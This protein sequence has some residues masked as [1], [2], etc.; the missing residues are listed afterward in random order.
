MT[1]H[2]SIAVDRTGPCRRSA[3]AV[4]LF[5]LGFSIAASAAASPPNPLSLN[6]S[7]ALDR[8]SNVWRV[9]EGWTRFAD[10]VLSLQIS[11]SRPVPISTHTRVVLHGFAGEDRYKTYDGLTHT[12][13]G[14]QAEFQYRS[15]GTYTA[16]IWGLALRASGEQ[17]KSDLRDSYRRSVAFTV[18][19]PITDRI[20]SF[21]AL[22]FLRR[23]GRSAVFDNRET[24]LRGDL[25]YSASRRATIYLGLDLRRGDAVS[26]APPWL[27][28]VDAAKAIALDD[29]FPSGTWYA[30]KVKADT[31]LGTLGF[32]YAL[33]TRHA[34]DVS[35]RRVQ[36]KVPDAG[37]RYVVNQASLAYLGR[38]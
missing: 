2:G 22:A 36:S 33:A 12:S 31:T 13:Y 26:S 32:N 20:S 23:D 5:A 9:P 10:R 17:Y 7:L 16:P 14:L 27:S 21:A 18:R 30:Y 35:L 38:F 29:A 15:A 11:A 19:K 28:Y 25:D 6:V 4:V 24:S 1:G 37:L 3:R 34:L 8:D